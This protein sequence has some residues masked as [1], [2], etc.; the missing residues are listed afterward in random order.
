MDCKIGGGGG[1][2]AGIK[3]FL[4][5]RDAM[6]LIRFRIITDGTLI[7]I[8]RPVRSLLV[9]GTAANVHPQLLHNCAASEGSTKFSLLRWIRRFC[10]KPGQR[11]PLLWQFVGVKE[12]WFDTGRL[13]W[14]MC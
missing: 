14:P 12:V 11:P 7:R 9:L 8:W 5:K 2:E 1:K 6:R 10:A 13:V 3:Y 4:Q